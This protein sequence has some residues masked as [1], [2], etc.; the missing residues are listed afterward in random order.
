MGKEEWFVL[1]TPMSAVGREEC[2]LGVAVE[3]P[4]RATQGEYT[5]Q[6]LPSDKSFAPSEGKSTFQAIKSTLRTLLPAPDEWKDEALVDKDGQAR[7]LYSTPCPWPKDLI[8]NSKIYPNSPVESTGVTASVKKISGTNMEVRALKAIATAIGINVEKLDVLSVPLLNRYDMESPEA[9]IKDLLAEPAYRRR[10]I[11]LLEHKEHKDNTKP[12]VVYIVT[13]FI[14]CSGMSIDTVCADHEELKV[15]VSVPSS[16][17]PI[18]IKAGAY[19]IKRSTRTAEYSA[20]NPV[21]VAV[22]YR[23]LSYFCLP[24]DSLQAYEASDTPSFLESVKKMTRNFFKTEVDPPKKVPTWFERTDASGFC[25]CFWIA[26]NGGKDGN[27]KAWFG[28][29]KDDNGQP[30][31]EASQSIFGETMNIVSEEEATDEEADNGRFPPGWFPLVSE[32]DE[33]DNEAE[34]EEKDVGL[35]AAKP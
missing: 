28:K 14:T 34:P 7:V 29:T 33:G 22:S 25:D 26:D 8:K 23:A 16:T 18:D 10:V 32:D 17:I 12:R 21:V 1:K 24:K 27:S 2:L 9:R 31:G 3:K 11:S 15:T 35:R 13:N 19:N 5:P 6:G 4:Y 30:Q 20:N